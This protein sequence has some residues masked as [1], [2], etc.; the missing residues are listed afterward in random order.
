MAR[1]GVWSRLLTL[2]RPKLR[3]SPVR[4]EGGPELLRPVARF[5]LAPNICQ[6]FPHLSGG[7]SHLTSLPLH[8]SGPL[9]GFFYSCTHAAPLRVLFLHFS[10]RSRTRLSSWASAISLSGFSSL[11]TCSARCSQSLGCGVMWNRLSVLRISTRYS[12]FP[13]ASEQYC[14]A[15][16]LPARVCWNRRW[17][18][19]SRFQGRAALWHP[20]QGGSFFNCSDSP[21]D[22]A[23]SVLRNATRRKLR[24][25]QDSGVLWRLL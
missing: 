2:P 18:R 15:P 24:L 20:P 23:P 10:L 19:V 25:G 22:P 12:G 14:T 3:P 11:L 1:C 4:P 5:H 17:G 16:T 13:S 8:V 7:A 21:S 6:G 9:E